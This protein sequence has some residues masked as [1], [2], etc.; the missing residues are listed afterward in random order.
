[1]P[2]G[3]YTAGGPQRGRHSREG[4]LYSTGEEVTW[5]GGSEAEG[6]HRWGHKGVQAYLSSLSL[7]EPAVEGRSNVF[8]GTDPPTR[9]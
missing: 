6:Q 8:G 7:S 4:R 9:G 2:I 3:S 1:M 5:G